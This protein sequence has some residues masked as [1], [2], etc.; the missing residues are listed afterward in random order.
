MAQK[1]R[2]R[3][4]DV[5][6]VPVESV[7]SEMSAE[8]RVIVGIDVAKR[9]FVAA[10]CSEAG[11]TR[12]RVRFEHPRQTRDFLTLLTAVQQAGRTVEVVM[13]PTG[14]YGDALRYQLGARSIAVYRVSNKHVADAAEMFDGSP[15]KHDGK[16]ASV[17]GW[18]HAQR[19]SKPWPELEPERRRVR[20][21]IAQRE[22]YDEPMAKLLSQVEP[23]LA[24]HFPELERFF[25]LSQR[26]TP[27]RLL[28][29]FGTPQS[30]ARAGVERVT[31]LMKKFGRR[32]P[33]PQLVREL[34]DA[35]RT[36]TG[37]E[38]VRE[39]IDLLR[40]MA[41]QM[42]HHM[43][44]REEVDER[45]KSA[46]ATIE[47]VAA[48]RA[49]G[50]VTA[51]VLYAYLGDPRSYGSAAAYEKAAGLNLVEHSS[52]TDPRSSDKVPRRISK[53]GPGIVRKYL[54]L[55]AMRLVHSDP[56]CKA[57]YQRRRSFTADERT[58]AIIAVERKLCRALFHIA[59]GEPFDAKKLFDV[60]RLGIQS[61]PINEAVA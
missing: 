16:D 20:A 2:Y 53:R 21:L 55:A 56:I 49:V 54:F 43:A 40:L 23:L 58:K 52:G 9:N 7:L 29:E 25:D 24:R 30:L 14:T 28:E 39:E 8:N 18:L 4:L 57:W 32:T 27:Y 59:R 15:S 42:L 48:M 10:L 33:D 44:L 60:R 45:I 35:A 47:P 38:M 26:K 12:L 3:S 31:A 5:Q 6:Q 13:E 41:R 34:V 51:A 1:I 36:T 46:S 11:E 61:S 19:R 50:A 22:L 17:I 37:S